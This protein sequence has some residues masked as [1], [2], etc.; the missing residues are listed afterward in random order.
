[1]D[2]VMDMDLALALIPMVAVRPMSQPV[3]MAATG[4]GS[5]SGMAM[6]GASA[7]CGFAAEAH[8]SSLN[9][10]GKSPHPAGFEKPF[11]ILA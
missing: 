11:R 2:P 5:A 6:S 9:Q 8:S 10:P 4:S 1:M 7:T 3:L